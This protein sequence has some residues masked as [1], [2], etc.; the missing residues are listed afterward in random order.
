[1]YSD[2]KKSPTQVMENCISILTAHMLQNTHNRLHACARCGIFDSEQQLHHLCYY[3]HRTQYQISLFIIPS[4]KVGMRTDMQSMAG[5]SI[6]YT[7][8]VDH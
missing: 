1:M 4:Q 5:Y 3:S 8:V 7:V 2:K 6:V